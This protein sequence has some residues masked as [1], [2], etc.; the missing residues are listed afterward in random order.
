[1][2]GSIPPGIRGCQALLLEADQSHKARDAS[3][4]RGLAC[5]LTNPHA[6]VTNVSSM[7]LRIAVLLL[8]C[9][10][11]AL[12]T[13]AGGVPCGMSI[14]DWCPAPPGDPCGVHHDTSSCRNDPRCYAIG[15]SGESVIAC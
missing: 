8:A 2:N 9:S 11:L 5:H 3:R 10:G 1:M 12:P 4:S 6:A 7:L 13:A 14:S 15:Y